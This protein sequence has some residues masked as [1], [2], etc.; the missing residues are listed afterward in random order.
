[1]RSLVLVVVSYNWRSAV[2]WVSDKGGRVRGV[3]IVPFR[4]DG[5]HHTP[6]DYTANIFWKHLDKAG[7]HLHDF[8]FG[9]RRRPSRPC[10]SHWRRAGHPTQ[11][12]HESRL[13]T[14]GRH[15]RPLP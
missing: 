5:H 3:A 8:T 7:R 10:R 1:L 12:F 4:K 11:L 14:V 13:R 2:T 9:E 15:A 6:L